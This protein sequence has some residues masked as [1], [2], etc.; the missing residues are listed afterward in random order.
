[1]SQV[2][3]WVKKRAQL[4]KFL[5]LIS[6][7]VIVV[8]EVLTIAKTTSLSQLKE[9]L[10]TLHPLAVLAMAVIGIVA[11]MPMLFYDVILTNLLPE[12]PA[13]TYVLQTSW[14]TNTINN[15][16]GFGGLI[17]TG[18]RT[19]FYG[20]KTEGKDLLKALSK[21]ILFFISGISIYCL[22][23]LLLIWFGH[24]A[25]FL[26]KYWLWL[27]GGSL[28]FPILLLVTHRSEAGFFDDLTLKIEGQLV[29]TSFLEWT[30][31]LTA[32]ISVGKLMGLDFSIAHIIPLYIACSIIGMVS[33]IPGALGSFDVMIL[34][35]LSALGIPHETA[36]I[37]IL[38][39]R[40]FYYLIPF[41]MGLLL[42]SHTVGGQFNQRYNGIPKEAASKVAHYALV[43]AL[44][45]AGILLVLS[46]TIPEAFNEYPIIGKLNPASFHFLTQTPSLIIGFLLL[47]M[48][49]GAAQKV[50]K[51]FMPTVIL[52]IGAITYVLWKEFS[53]ALVVILVLVLVFVMLSR[54]QFYREKL[55]YSWEML[56]FDGLLYSGLALLYIIIGVYNLPNRHHR[57]RHDFLIF[58]SEHMWLL[59]LATIVITATLL[60]IFGHYLSKSQVVLGE[61]VNQEKVMA[62]LAEYGGNETSQLIFLGDKKLFF[63]EDSKGK[64]VVLFQYK[65]KADKCLVMGEPVGDPAY[66]LA[67][68]DAFMSQADLLG[69][70]LVFYEVQESFVML[71]HEHGFDF[72]K[73]GE[74]AYVDVQ[75]FTLSGK[76]LK[77][78]R[79]LLNKM[80]RENFQ[81]DLLEPPFSAELMTELRKISDEWL[82]GQ[83]EKSYSMGFFD[84]DYLSRAPIAVIKNQEGQCVAFANI[85][86]TYNKEQ[87]TID[88]MRHYREAPSGVMDSLFTNLFE[89][90]KEQEYR[91]FNMGMAPLANVGYAKNSF[92]QER[93]AHYIYEYGTHFYSFQG[94]RNYKSKYATRW[95][96]KYTAYP[97]NS[98]LIYTLI[99]L[100]ILVNAPKEKK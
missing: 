62:L 19:Q 3:G 7:S 37:W 8:R 54:S 11:V 78:V 52:L 17:S 81:F 56:T 60:L 86:P 42:L 39:Y 1:M 38:L 76:K 85:M 94:L 10:A 87:M 77:G 49:R 73:M 66:F 71:L 80:E 20:K 22:I 95:V 82:A 13:L 4:I 33:M 74:E 21:V 69:Y 59:G 98:S 90:A 25:P 24:G 100:L 41:A 48:G 83:A 88:L 89:V 26:H 35:G 34:L 72:L 79:S 18:L 30:G 45:V 65:I 64:P 75:N 23:S 2:V 51:A 61:A 58:P 67:A 84:E 40:L 36:V 47:A 14:I 31:V 5:F 55:V 92:F 6:V 53:W 63:Y 50:K 12:K 57:V 44:Y 16:C 15:L 97:K 91:F 93:V 43:T 68:I 46:A 28:Y 9:V 32:F 96:A 27:A 70:R 99:Q 29:A